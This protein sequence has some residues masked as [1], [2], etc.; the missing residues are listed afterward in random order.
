CGRQRGAWLERQSAIRIQGQ[1]GITEGSRQDCVIVL[2]RARRQTRNRAGR[3]A[4]GRIRHRTGLRSRAKNHT[5]AGLVPDA[6]R[7]WREADDDPVGEMRAV[8]GFSEVKQ[9]SLL[10]R[11]DQ[12]VTATGPGHWPFRAIGDE[13]A[14]AH[15]G[16]KWARDSG[17]W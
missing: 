16:R 10:L 2:G 4:G 7:G 13:F 11:L 1:A 3:M 6:G 12:D 15:A 9:L 17:W 8:G 5:Q 14:L